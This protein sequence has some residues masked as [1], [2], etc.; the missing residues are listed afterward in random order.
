MSEEL[1]IETM[2]P[3]P[4]TTI[5]T[6]P[7]ALPPLPTNPEQVKEVWR[8]TVAKLPKLNY[9]ETRTKLSDPRYRVR[10]PEKLLTGEAYD[11]LLGYLLNLKSDLFP[12]V[13]AIE[14]NYCILNRALKNMKA[15]FAG[16]SG[17]KNEAERTAHAEAWAIHLEDLVAQADALRGTANRTYSLLD[18][19]ST[20]VARMLKVLDNASRTGMLDSTEARDLPS[21]WRNGYDFGEEKDESWK[22][23]WSIPHVRR[24][25]A[26]EA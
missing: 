11:T 25:P 20:Q 9:E 15:I 24:S 26:E 8:R 1:N 2:S 18:D 3:E 4:R 13:D 23:E 5:D 16:I 7:P 10:L 6:T 19:A 12:T 17:G 22:D 14:V 21:G